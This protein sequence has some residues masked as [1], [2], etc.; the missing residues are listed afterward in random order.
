M[1]SISKQIGW[2]TESNI[3]Y[4]ILGQLKK[5]TG[6]ISITKTPDL[7]HVTNM[8]TV[9][10]D[11]ITVGGLQILDGSQGNGKILESDANGVTSWEFPPS[12]NVFNV[13]NYGA[14][15]DGVIISDATI[16]SGSNNLT[17]STTVFTSADIG[18]YI[19]VQAGNT[20]GYAK[21]FTILSINNSHSIILSST[22]GANV[23]NGIAKYGTD[24]TTFIQA[25]INAAIAA[26]S[27]TVFF[28]RG[29]Y[30]LAGALQS[31]S[32]SQLVFPFI[33]NP[34]T[35]S[36]HS[37]QI[38][39]QGE[40]CGAKET[41][42]LAVTIPSSSGTTLLSFATGSGS[43]PSI[44]ATRT[45]NT[46]QYTYIDL[47]VKNMNLQVMGNTSTGAALG[48]INGGNFINFQV[49]NLNVQVDVPVINSILPTNDYAGIIFTQYGFASIV[50]STDIQVSGFKYGAI[51][52]EHYRSRNAQMFSCYYGYGVG[53]SG[54]HPNDLS[55]L[56]AWCVFPIAST[57]TYPT[58]HALSS[59]WIYG[60]IAIEGVNQGTRWYNYQ[61]AIKDTSNFLNG[62]LEY[63]YTYSAIGSSSTFTKNGGTNLECIPLTTFLATNVNGI[64]AD[65]T[66]T[67]TLPTGQTTLISGTKALTIAGL[68]T[69]S[70]AFV[71]LVT[72]SGVTLTTSY[73][74]VCTASTLTIQANIAAGTINTADGSTLNYFVI[75]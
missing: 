19:Q 12:V 32:N 1:A 41:T 62:K 34:T 11:P 33:D 28:P 47:T 14:T 51:I 7:Q 58:T 35:Y 8:G 17:T 5:L 66:G 60:T 69:N 71:Q 73:Q 50:T 22:A 36:G 45:V 26:Y 25:A 55:G 30:I 6:I 27:S 21:V 29:I 37:V 16:S 64:S 56:F 46:T 39:M 40:G 9:T 43:F 44:I 63:R 67:I 20:G 54:G 57:I 15:A 3:L 49:E 74:A 23:S 24:Q 72:P 53:T 18:K 31:P 2:S 59:N 70:R 75:N 48:A 52:G 38:T 61:N 65:V 4:Y 42:I 13:F 68:T 10:T